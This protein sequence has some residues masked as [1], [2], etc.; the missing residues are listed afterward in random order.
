[1]V[2]IMKTVSVNVYSFDGLSE[3]AKEKARNWWRSVDD[4]DVSHVLDSFKAE[5]EEFG[6]EVSN[7]TYSV[8]WSQGDGAGF[9]YEV[10]LSK[11]L[12]A[13]AKEKEH[14]TIRRLLKDGKINALVRGTQGYNHFNRTHHNCVEVYYG[15]YV[16]ARGSAIL[17][18]FDKY[19][20][21]WINDKADDLYQRL[22]DALE[23]MHSDEYIDECLRTNEYDFDELGRHWTL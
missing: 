13:T 7:F 8:S 14:M 19:L 16:S 22:S 10:N 20:I 2:P 1:M 9:D 21:K 3:S 11:W 5:M 12:D 6:V 23:Y 4:R 18:E 15:V 17:D